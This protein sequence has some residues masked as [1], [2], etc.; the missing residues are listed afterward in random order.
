MKR[1]KI[2]K[3][4]ILRGTDLSESQVDRLV[5]EKRKELKGLLSIEDGL[6]IIARDYDVA[7]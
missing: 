4:R 5:R 1:I 3:E 2:L 6:K 7:H